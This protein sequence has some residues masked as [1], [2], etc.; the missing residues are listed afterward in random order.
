MLLAFPTAFE[1]GCR[2]NANYPGPWGWTRVQFKGWAGCSR[3]SKQRAESVPLRGSPTTEG[4]CL[5]GDTLST[6]FH[7]MR[8]TTRLQRVCVGGTL[9]CI[10]FCKHSKMRGSCPRWLQTGRYFSLHD[11]ADLK[12]LSLS[13]CL[14]SLSFWKQCLLHD[15]QN[16][17]LEIVFF[18]PLINLFF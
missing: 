12:A 6:P 5:S 17:L 16:F 3:T 4:R 18:S 14:Y 10:C 8:Y 11:A 15:F 13:H 7:H 9:V 2:W 1:D